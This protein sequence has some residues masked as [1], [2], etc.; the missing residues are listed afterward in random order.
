M[1]T[2]KQMAEGLLER[3]QNRDM[4]SWLDKERFQ[5]LFKEAVKDY[6]PKLKA[7]YADQ[8]IYGVS[9]EIGGVVQPVYTETFGTYIYFNTEEMYREKSKDCQEDEKD[10]YRFEPWA[11]WEAVFA[12]SFLF[13]K[14]QDYLLQSSLY[15]C[16]D[17]CSSCSDYR[18]RLDDAAAAWYEENVLVFKRT[19]DEER[20]QIRMWMAEVLGQLRKE[21]FWE[22]QGSADLYVIPFGGESDIETEELMETYRIMDVGCH[23]GEYL[24]YLKSCDLI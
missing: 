2:R 15:G 1:I 16:S 7:E 10:Y 14:L 8:S 23:K 6:C 9:F 24:D 12:E 17:V 4:E 5:T 19:F 21:G 11:E 3:Y 22:E 20:R 13:G 18:N